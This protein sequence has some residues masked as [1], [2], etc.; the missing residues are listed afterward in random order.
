M[1]IN[2]LRKQINDIDSDITE[3]FCKRM[4]IARMIAEYKKEH[5][6]ECKNTLL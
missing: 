6:I 4:D 5:G 3:L 2:E 1:D